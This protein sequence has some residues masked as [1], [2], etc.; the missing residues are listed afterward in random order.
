MRAR[1]RDST[2]LAVGSGLSGLLAYVFFAMVTRASGPVAAAPV[3]VLWTYWSFAAAALTF[4]LQHWIAH[5]SA[6][7]LGEGAV[8]AALPR[9]AATV[10]LLSLA[11]GALAWVVREDLFRRGD[12]WFPALIGVVTLG[13]AFV[14]VVRGLL[15]ARLRFVSVAVA[16]VAE[17]G[18]RC[19]IAA[20]LIA[21]SARES[22]G[23]GVALA[24]GQLVGLGWPSATRTRG[25]ATSGSTDSWARFVLGA[26]AGQL[27]GQ[28]VLTGGPVVLALVGGSPGEV[29]ALFAS[30][31]L[32]RAP[33]TLTL[34]MVAP[35]TGR[36]TAMVVHRDVATLR[37]LRW[38]TVAL[39]GLAVGLAALA[40]GLAGPALIR[41][42]FGA[43]VQMESTAA[44]LTA[45]GSALALG[46]LALTLAVMA[47]GRTSA[48]VGSWV[49]ALAASVVAFVV[50]SGE[51]PA[52]VGTCTAFLVAEAVAF[53]GLLSMDFRMT[54][55]LGRA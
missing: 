36:L 11:I 19:L 38:T 28:A 43:G 32:F 6:A 18:L 50:L 22:V 42:V 46:N 41:L 9:V 13:S 45:A 14:G 8:R 15:A 20:A 30:L 17:N 27:V 23:F 34:G 49:L 31:A 35:L 54:E 21:A 24:A 25:T 26:G 37:R 39:T 55:R 40:G 4:P 51:L 33:Y 48:V 1:L 16:L 10:A 12:A 5:S 53:L 29:T 3:S 7:H 44:L 2:A 52:L 47:H